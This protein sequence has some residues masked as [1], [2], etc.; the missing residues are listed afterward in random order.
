[1]ARRVSRRRRQGRKGCKE[2]GWRS[3]RRSRRRC[4]CRCC[5]AARRS[6]AA[7][8]RRRRRRR[9]RCRCRRRCWRRGQRAA[10]AGAAVRSL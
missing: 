10:V 2:E 7:A 5:C 4:R 3:R 9:C 8:R 6:Q 1:V